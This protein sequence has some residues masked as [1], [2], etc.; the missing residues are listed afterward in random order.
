[1]TSAPK[2]A[3]SKRLAPAA[4]NSIAQQ[5]RPIGIG[6]R[7][8]LRNQFSAVSRR[9]TITSPSL[10]ESKPIWAVACISSRSAEPGAVSRQQRNQGRKPRQAEFVNFFT[11][12][13]NRSGQFPLEG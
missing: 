6:Q 11:S 5:A 2:R 7:E 9:V 4:I 8:F 13:P 12:S 1:M 10:L 3:I